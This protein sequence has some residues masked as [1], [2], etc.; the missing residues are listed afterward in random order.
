VCAR[1]RARARVCVCSVEGVAG[2]Y[3]LKNGTTRAEMLDS[4]VYEVDKAD[5]GA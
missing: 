2:G 4:L 3:G 1:A 5:A